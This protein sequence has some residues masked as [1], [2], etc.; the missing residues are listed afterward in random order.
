M[1]TSR[2]ERLNSLIHEKLAGLMLR[3]LNVE[4]QA[5][6]SI[7]S[8]DTAPDLSQSKVYVSLYADS[9][10]RVDATF[11]LLKKNAKHLRYLLAG[12]IELRKVPRLYFVLDDSIARSDRVTRLIEQTV[13]T[14]D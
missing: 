1:K 7:T 10:A 14:D 5:I 2:V 11:E 3:E 12:E 8:V 9:P 13:K 6:V 4:S